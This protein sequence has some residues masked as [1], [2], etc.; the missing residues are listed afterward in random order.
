MV[1]HGAIQG[2]VM[3]HGGEAA[4]RREEV[5]RVTVTHDMSVEMGSLD[6]S[7]LSGKGER[8]LVAADTWLIVLRLVWPE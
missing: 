5:F 8:V 3:E 2:R 7:M 6:L 1:E 4:E